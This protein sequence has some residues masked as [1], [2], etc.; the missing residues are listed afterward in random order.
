MFFIP[1]NEV[2]LVCIDSIVRSLL[3]LA[4]GL[5]VNESVMQVRAHPGH[6]PTVRVLQGSFQMNV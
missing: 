5:S 2:N 6:A 4:R 1:A 3:Q